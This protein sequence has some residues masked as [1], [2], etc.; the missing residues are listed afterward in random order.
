MDNFA[1]YLENGF[2]CVRIYENIAQ[3]RI[4]PYKP[5]TNYSETIYQDFELLYNRMNHNMNQYS[6]T[7]IDQDNFLTNISYQK[8]GNNKKKLSFVSLDSEGEVLCEC[9]DYHLCDEY[10]VKMKNFLDDL[11]AYLRV[12]LNVSFFRN[13]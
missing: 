13:Q 9:N 3:H 4:F 11:K 1:I 7:M 8:D 10:I 2:I 6:F 12:V 5:Y